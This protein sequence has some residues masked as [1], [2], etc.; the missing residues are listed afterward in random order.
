MRRP[1]RGASCQRY[2]LRV[3]RESV[4]S[5]ALKMKYLQQTQGYITREPLALARQHQK[6]SPKTKRSHVNLVEQRE[7]EEG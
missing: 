4:S 2:L 5:S 1:A 7:G 6:A 3:A